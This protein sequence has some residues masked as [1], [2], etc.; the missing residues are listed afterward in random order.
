M[1]TNNGNVIATLP[2]GEMDVPTLDSENKLIFA[3]NGEA[4]YPSFGSTART[5]TNRSAIFQHSLA[6]RL[7]FD[8]KTKRLFLSPQMEAIPA[9]EG[10][11]LHE[12]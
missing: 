8:L 6:R 4:A 5:S 2:I 1:D 11:G 10:K 12:T 3:S 9:S 7:A